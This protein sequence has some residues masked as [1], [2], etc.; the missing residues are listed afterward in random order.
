MDKFKA[1]KHTL[2]FTIILTIAAIAFY[3]LF[4]G[5]IKEKNENISLIKNEVNIAVQKEI[6]LR[7][8]KDLIKETKED[9]LKLDTYFIADDKVVDFIENLEQ[10]SKYAGVDIEVVS[11]DVSQDVKKNMSESLDLDFKVSGKWR[12]IFH[13]LTLIENMPL[14]I[15]ILKTNL[16]VVYSDGVNKKSSGVWEGFFSISTIKLK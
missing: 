15:K 3:V 12:D 8:V 4:F 6:N 1:T 9:R 14:K 5:N 10:L 11:V 2:I 16:K 7:S 13:L